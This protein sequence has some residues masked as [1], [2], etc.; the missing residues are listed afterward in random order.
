MFYDHEFLLHNTTYVTELKVFVHSYLRMFDI[1]GYC[2]AIEHGM[3]T[4]S[5]GEVIISKE[6]IICG[7]YIL[8]GSNV[9]VYSSS[10]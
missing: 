4:I 10:S 2:T 1:L 7:L 9:V 6:S 3:L 8:V 5:H